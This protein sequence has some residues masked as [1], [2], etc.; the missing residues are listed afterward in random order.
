M[1]TEQEPTVYL[2]AAARDLH[3]IEGY[4][5]FGWTIRLTRARTD[6]HELYILHGPL[7]HAKWQAMR[8]ASGLLL[9]NGDGRGIE[10]YPTYEKALEALDE[11]TPHWR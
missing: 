1:T 4:L 8:L 11:Y 3:E 9:R 7:R 6:R 5:G 2:L 10:P